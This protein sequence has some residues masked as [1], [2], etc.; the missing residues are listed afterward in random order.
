MLPRQMVP[1]VR[2]THNASFID[3]SSSLSSSHLLFTGSPDVA[4]ILRSGP[5]TQH[6][7]RAASCVLCS[8]P[9][10]RQGHAIV[11]HDVLDMTTK[12]EV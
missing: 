7:S 8:P 11:P 1:E 3:E 2:I 10:T 4:T 12:A 5:I 9:H 6:M